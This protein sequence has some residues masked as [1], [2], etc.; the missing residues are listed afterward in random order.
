MYYTSG[1][2]RKRKDKKGQPWQGVLR[3]K[4]DNG[5][6]HEVKKSFSQAKSKGEAQAMHKA[7]WDQMEKEAAQKELRDRPQTTVVDAIRVYLERQHVMGIL[8]TAT[9]QRQYSQVHFAIEPYLGQNDFYTLTRKDVSDYIHEVSK[10]YSAQAVR[11]YF[12]IILKTYKDAVRNGLISKN[13]C[14][15]QELPKI[16]D[17]RINYL[18]KEGRK[19]FLASINQLDPSDYRYIVGMLAYYTGMR[20]SEI[21]ALEWGD[22]NFAVDRIFV[23]KAASAVK[24]E[25]GR[26]VVEI[27]QTKSSAGKRTIPISL[28]VKEA[29]LN[30]LGDNEPRSSDYVLDK[31]HRNPSNLCGCFLS[32]SRSRGIIGVLGKPITLHGLRHT[33]ATVAVQSNADIKSLSSILGH[34][35]ADITL[36]IY[37][38]DDEDAKTQAMNNLAAFWTHEEE[39]DI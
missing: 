7:W 6:W 18:D 23:N 8:S 22:I 38:S 12:S 25:H 36:N 16:P 14:D 21:A 30:Y 26:N 20:A 2:V 32:W 31:D 10:K 15:L 27:K 4:D 13:P 1:N 17:H 33:F 24:D 3:H 19:K 28:Q 5:E 37:A 39:N 9:F 29:L 34:A 11:N 35:R